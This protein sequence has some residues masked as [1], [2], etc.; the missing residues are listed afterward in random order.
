MAS[1]LNVTGAVTGTSVT[2]T[3]AD[4]TTQLTLKSTDD[5]L[6]SGPELDF[7][8]LSASPADNDYLGRV[9]YIGRNDNAQVGYWDEF[10]TGKVRFAF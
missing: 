2:L 4:N 3:T 9:K 6:N 5:D 10:A 8:R 1:T 7:Y